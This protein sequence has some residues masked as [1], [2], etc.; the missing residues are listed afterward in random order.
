MRKYLLEGVVFASG[1]IVMIFEIVG[2]RVFGP[3]FGTSLFV[4]TT[5]I[6]VVLGSLSIGYY[7][8]GRCADKKATYKNLSMIL[9]AAGICISIMIF[10]KDVLLSSLQSHMDNVSG[11][12]LIGS[13]ILF[14]PTSIFL[15]MVSSYA[16]KLRIVDLSTSGAAIGRLYALSTCGSIFGTFL[17]GFYLIPF[18]GTNALL[19][20]LAIV[21]LL[22]STLLFF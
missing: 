14:A 10:I 15:G 17:A 1:G 6:G 21:V 2:S 22:F 11:A 18:F 20:I 12:L 19:A 9:F 13:I 5:L 3:Y 16:A 4:W 8:G 7:V